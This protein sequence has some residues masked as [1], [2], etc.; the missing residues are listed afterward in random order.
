MKI[1]NEKFEVGDLF[2][3][4][5]PKIHIDEYKS[6]IGRDDE[7]CVISLLVNDQQASK[8][9]VDFLEKRYNFILDADISASEIR[10]GSYLV[11]IELLRRNRVIEQ[12]LKILSDL[13][14]ASKI[15]IKNWKFRYVTDEEYYPVTKEELK[16]HVPLSPKAYKKTVNE[17]IKEIKQL[18]GL[19]IH[20]SIKMTEDLQALQHAAGIPLH[21][22]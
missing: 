22:K 12:L 8:D 14:A 5:E 13:V 10:P 4:L 7:V 3:V 2:L 19:P 9:L 15:E 18:S 17:P 6:K 20:E 16:K 1:L 11:F 21:K